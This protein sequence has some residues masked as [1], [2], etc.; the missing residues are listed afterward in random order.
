MGHEGRGWEEIVGAGVVGW[1]S[2]SFIHAG[3]KDLT[4]KFPL[5]NFLSIENGIPIILREGKV[6]PVRPRLPESPTLMI[7]CCDE[8]LPIHFLSA[9]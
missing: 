9:F 6:H 3:I 4:H 5:K 1:E 7:T 2:L 8:I